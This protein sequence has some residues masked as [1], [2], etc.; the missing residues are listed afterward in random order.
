MEVIAMLKNAI[1]KVKDYK[2]EIF[3]AAYM[4]GCVTLSALCI[5]AGVEQYLNTKETRKM[6]QRLY[7][8]KFN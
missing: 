3:M 1:E 8:A 7:D 4:V 6:V 5:K 2:Y